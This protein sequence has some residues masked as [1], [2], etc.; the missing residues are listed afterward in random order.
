M[1]ELKKNIAIKCDSIE[2]MQECRK[3]LIKMGYK[4]DRDW[5]DKFISL[6]YVENNKSLYVIIS[7]LISY[8]IFN[9]CFDSITFKEFF[10][11]K[12][13]WDR[14]ILCVII[15]MLSILSYKQHKRITTL[16]QRL[17]DYEL[18]IKPVRLFYGE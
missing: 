9:Y 6:P 12:I 3:R 8:S 5:N 7:D 4:D 15:L 10:N 11:K 14:I 2:Q 1:K 17:Y 16:E 18:Y 13:R